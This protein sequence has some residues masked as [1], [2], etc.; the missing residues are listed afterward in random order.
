MKRGMISVPYHIAL[1]QGCWTEF[2]GDQNPTQFT[3]GVMGKDNARPSATS[4]IACGRPAHGNATYPTHWRPLGHAFQIAF[5]FPR[6]DKEQEKALLE[7]RL[8]QLEQQP[9]EKQ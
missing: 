5:L 3:G 8:K 1:H 4:Q 7:K 2:R 9:P 6:L